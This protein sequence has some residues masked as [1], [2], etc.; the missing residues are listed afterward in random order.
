MC[1]SGP[2]N[3]YDDYECSWSQ[4]T[5]NLNIEDLWAISFKT[6]LWFCIWSRGRW[7]T[8]VS[9]EG[10]LAALLSVAALEMAQSSSSSLSILDALTKDGVTSHNKMG[11]LVFHSC[12]LFSDGCQLLSFFIIYR[13]PWPELVEST[14]RYS[15]LRILTSQ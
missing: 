14:S 13:S 2:C 10:K 6:K 12:L 7:V 5:Y 11:L 15:L 8:R 1:L 4:A 9:S 3:N